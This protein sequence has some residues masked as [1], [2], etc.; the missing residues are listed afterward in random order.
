VRVRQ[1]GTTRECCA[2]FD[3]AGG[4]TAVDARAGGTVWQQPGA[5]WA[6]SATRT[7]V[8]TA[9]AGRV[10]LLTGALL[11]P[12]QLGAGEGYGRSAIVAG[13]AYHSTRDSSCVLRA[14]DLDTRVSLWSARYHAFE[15][16]GA[17]PVV[18]GGVV[19]VFDQA[20]EL[21]A[22]D[23]SSARGWPSRTY[24]YSSQP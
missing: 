12:F 9:E 5:R 6:T 14:L 17:G 24:G 15:V 3:A 11:D 22:F 13:V 10:D 1:P 7:L 23:A 2:I 19:W 20:G 4:L 8:M 18:A 21:Q 16:L